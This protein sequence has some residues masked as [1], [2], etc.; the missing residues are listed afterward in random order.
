MNGAF[1]KVYIACMT[2]NPDGFL[3]KDYMLAK[4]LYRKLEQKGIHTFLI[5]KCNPND[6]TEAIDSAD[7]LIVAGTC[8]ET[9]LSDA[10]RNDYEDFI[11][12]V[13]LS[14]KRKWRVFIYLR[15]ITREDLPDYLTLHRSFDHF[16]TDELVKKIEKTLSA[17]E[18]RNCISDTDKDQGDY[19]DPLP[20]CLP[21]SA[22][23]VREYIDDDDDDYSPVSRPRRARRAPQDYS[24]EIRTEEDPSQAEYQ[25][26]DDDD[27]STIFGQKDAAEESAAEESPTEQPEPSPFVPLTPSLPLSEPEKKPVK[28]K[29][30]KVNKV[31]FSVVAPEEVKP[32]KSSIIDLLM[33]TRSQKAIVKRTIEQAKEKSSEAARSAGSVSVRQDSQVT[34]L[35]FSDDIEITDDCRR[36]IW[37]G[38]A[39][40]FKFRVTPPADY[41]KKEID[42]GCCVQFD[43]IEITRLYFTVPVGLK[44]K[45]AVRFTRKDCRRAFV[46]YSHKDKLR[47]VEQ[48]LAIQEV[49]PKLRFWMDNRSMTAGDMWRNA[50][51]SAIRNADVFL[52]FWSVSARDSSEVRKEWEYALK[53]EQSKKRRRKNGARFIS[54]VPLDSPSECPPPEELEDLHFG[55]PSFDSDV[56]NIEKVKIWAVKGKNIKFL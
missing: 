25:E 29:P 8:T 22:E 53:L 31:D 6:R 16:Q 50:I 4:Q 48:L 9:L 19:S 49:A 45:V 28:V 7:I 38:D 39:L 11:A 34:A 33:Y 23:S 54:P 40:D 10:V 32:G 20:E 47:V 44:K 30:A 42:F 56:E 24:D 35:L 37:N 43:G 3:T 2:K 13:E 46:S 5:E 41:S 27:I 14:G 12:A 18:P 52:L 21:D 55:D 15:G 26:N 36:M 17:E 1:Y 51:A